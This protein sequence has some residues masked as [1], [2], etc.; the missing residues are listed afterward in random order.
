MGSIIASCMGGFECE[1]MDLSA[2]CR[3]ML[4]VLV[5]GLVHD[6]VIVR[7]LDQ[8]LASWVI[9]LPR[10][11]LSRTLFFKIGGEVIL[12]PLTL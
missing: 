4:G 11:K 10:T 3:C 1:C 7:G 12:I 5:N 9:V 8:D 6:A 2:S